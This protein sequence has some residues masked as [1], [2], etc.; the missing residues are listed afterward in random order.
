MKT[1]LE[2]PAAPVTCITVL[3]AQ[4]EPTVK[5]Y[6]LVPGEG[7]VCTPYG[8]ENLFSH[9]RRRVAGI[10]E[11][12]VL[13]E[14][15]S[16]RSNAILIRGTSTNNLISPCRR[17]SESFPEE[18][19]CSWL[20]IDFDDLALPDHIASTSRGAIEHI[21]KSLP[22]E[23]HDV[24]YFYQFSASAGV[25]KADGTPLK[26]GLN[27]HVFFWLDKATQGTI[28]ADYLE[29]HC[30]QTNFYEKVLDRSG[31][32]R[33]KLGVDTAVLRSSV[34]P[35]YV[36]FPI[37]GEGVKCTLTL[38]ARQAMVSKS[39][40]SVNLPEFDAN[41][42]TATQSK[43]LQ[44]RN[45]YKRECGF[46]EARLIARAVS[47]ALSVSSYSRKISG[48]SPSANKIFIQAR[49]YGEDSSSIILYFEDESSPGSWYVN[50]ASPHVARRFGDGN[51]LSLKELSDGAFAYVRDTLAWFTEVQ[52]VELA[53]TEGGYLPD[54]GA[55]AT[56]RNSLIE[57]PTGS[58]KTTAFCRF[59]QAHRGKV[60]LYAAQTIA[61]V[62]QMEADLRTAGIR[63]V[64]YSEFAKGDGLTPAVY[65]TTN[66]SL[67]KFV[68]AAIEQGANYLLVIDEAHMA[69]DDFMATELKNRLLEDAIGRAERSLFM[70]ATITDMQVA[71][72]L[73][74]ISRKCGALTPE[75]YTGYKF[76]PVK[77]NPVILKSI[78]TIGADLVSLMR[79][80]AE[81]KAAGAVIP[82][83]VLITPTS[84][85][86]RF[87]RI[88]EDFD[89]LGEAN[90]V[91]RQEATAEA[92]EEAR[93][94]T[95]PILIASPM[96]ALGLNFVV[97]PERFWCYFSHLQI[98]TSQIIQ[99]L[100]RANRGS[101]Q[102]EVRL[103]HG[104]LNRKPIVVPPATME[105]LRIQNA[106]TNET[107]VQ[108]II[109]GYFHV[110][111]PTYNSLRAAEKQTAKALAWLIDGDRIQNYRIANDWT[112]ILD[113][114]DDD[115]EL[116][117]ALSDD[118]ADSYLI[119][120]E[121]IA[122]GLKDES[123]LQLLHRLDLLR[124]AEANLYRG[125]TDR[126]SRDLEAERRAV[127]MVLC[128]IDDPEQTKAI[129]PARIRRVFG[130]LRPYLTSQFDASRTPAW[131]L[132]AAEK[133]EHLIPV[134][135]KLKQLR[136]GEIDGIKFAQ[137][138]RRESLR[139]GVLALAGNESSYLQTWTLKLK[140]LDSLS[141]ELVKRASKK[142]RVEI[143]KEQF[144]LAR[145]FLATIGVHFEPAE[146]GGRDHDP[147]KPV[148]PGWDLDSM[149]FRLRC[150]A[151]SL[152]KMPA[153]EVD[154]D[155]V[156][157]Q[158][159]GRPISD[160]TC[161]TCVHGKP[162]WR[163]ALGRPR[164]WP[165]NDLEDAEPNC[166]TYA[167]ISVP[168][169][170]KKEPPL[171]VHLML[172]VGEHLTKSRQAQPPSLPG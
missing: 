33:I 169:A 83:T 119:D 162:A 150:E 16:A 35:H 72:L 66:E 27:V 141:E 30:Y 45:E 122:A 17:I 78:S 55:F 115:R 44:V 154:L 67:K 104:A 13:V 77:S 101:T 34:Q 139:P 133:T 15:F 5:R 49:P 132:A 97:Q 32:P 148:V 11:L 69:L 24:S 95:R 116:Y 114:T 20:M 91:S 3:T 38:A 127:L 124:Q 170:R 92:I 156:H 61:L 120:I 140:K 146:D 143:A 59:A 99:T 22:P 63:V 10:G 135:E 108:G 85:M 65:V 21:I 98:D 86:R 48:A 153:E 102:C 157:V 100:N 107:T 28:L 70:T 42:R 126:V 57:A 81:K 137:L 53:L 18:P 25:L 14:E 36:G 80:Y 19:G 131:R 52:H 168:L 64:H 149:I 12:G 142:R 165:E 145:Q 121:E 147:T 6:D 129:D 71:K 82:R 68:Y 46:V 90:V 163:C 161:A 9:V 37:I 106:L 152:V 125:N 75:N 112:E 171:L 164:E 89:L 73:E 50:K 51:T 128:Q 158:W 166:D 40:D 109:D 74:T 113:V 111:R 79:S 58:G 47:G 84:R 87:L 118:A 155:K 130:E 160:E 23:F 43:R 134:L 29:M 76:A 41:L 1:L 62:K 7:V 167:A 88:L 4:S 105:R 94:S 117:K 39:E 93:T 151:K 159:L 96:F 123:Q 144:E 136:S 56:A 172:P 138:M 26:H 31:A 110:S 2:T 54:I 103:Y 60:I 8:Q